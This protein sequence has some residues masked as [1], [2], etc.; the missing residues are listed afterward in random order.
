MSD[1]GMIKLLLIAAG[2]AIGA[3]LRYGISGFSFRLL[4]DA[5]PWGTLIVNM[6]GSFAIGLLWAT[7]E[8]MPFPPQLSAFLFIGVLGAFTT[9][10]TYSLES[11]NLLREGEIR[12]G[13]TYMIGSNVLGLVV[14]LLGFVCAR[15]F[16]GLWFKV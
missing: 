3:L 5:F 15:Y 4:G 6:L 9:F 10:S 12:L 7:A 2:G 14:V 8:R 13:L 16:L 11:F 1:G